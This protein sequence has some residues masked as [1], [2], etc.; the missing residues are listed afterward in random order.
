M[1]DIYGDTPARTDA[2]SDGE[3]ETVKIVTLSRTIM[4]CVTRTFNFHAYSRPSCRSVS[5]NALMYLL[6]N[7]KRATS[8]LFSFRPHPM[9]VSEH[10]LASFEGCPR[11][12]LRI[13][14][15]ILRSPKGSGFRER[16]VLGQ[17]TVR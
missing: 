12:P 10:E 5:N 9:R 16:R 14:L 4:V 8:L 3:L 11:I 17:D 7:V 2:E 15:A 6:L 1:C 13:S